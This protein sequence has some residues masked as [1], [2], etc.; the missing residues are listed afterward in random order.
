MICGHHVIT[1]KIQKLDKPFAVMRKKVETLENDN[2][3]M[4]IDCERDRIS[5]DVVA[6]V[7]QKI[8]FKNRPKPIIIKTQ[9]KKI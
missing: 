6:F 9:P 1:G 5:Y 4:E 8:I 7:K 2:D 3:M